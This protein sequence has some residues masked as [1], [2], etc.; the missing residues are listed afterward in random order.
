MCLSITENY[1]KKKISFQN[2]G[3]YVGKSR[4]TYGRN[5]CFICFKN[6]STYTFNEGQ[7]LIEE[8]FISLP[9]IDSCSF[10]YLNKL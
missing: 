4:H 10:G 2:C 7:Y 8:Y 1:G 9:F 3:G 5:Y 6:M